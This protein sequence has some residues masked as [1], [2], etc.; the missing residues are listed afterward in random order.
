MFFFV[1]V[2]EGGWNREKGFGGAAYVHLSES[3]ILYIIQQSEKPEVYMQH[4]QSI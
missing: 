1:Y 2:C 4:L 3:V